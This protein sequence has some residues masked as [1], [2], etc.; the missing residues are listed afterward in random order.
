MHRQLRNALLMFLFLAFFSACNQL[1]DHAR[2]IPKDAV[3][4]VGINLKSLGKK[5]AW[6]VI[7]G[8]KLF[9]EMQARIAEKN[10]KDA[11]SGIEKSGIDFSNTLYVYVKT[12]TR[13]K[14]GNRITGLVPLSDAGQWEAYVKQMFPQAEIKQH[15]D[16]KEVSLGRDMYVGWNNKLMI[17]INT[18]S[19]S[20]DNENDGGNKLN[21]SSTM[22]QADVS[23]E[24]DNAFSVTKENS[25]IG[26]KHFS[27]LEM[28][29]H[30]ITFWLNY[31]QLMT[32]YMSGN[33]AQKMGVSLSNALWKEVT[34]TSGFDFKKG[35]IT[36]DTHWYFSNDMK[37]IGIEMG[38]T[39]VDKEMI[40]RLPTQNMDMLMDLHLS[41]KGV[42]AMMEK[43]GLL[44]LA[45]LG[46]GTQGMNVDDIL[47]GFTGDMAMVMND[48][49][50][51]TE[52]VTDSFMG[53][54]V[55]HQNQKP[56]VNACYVM[57]INKKEK[58]QKLLQLAKDNGLQSF[59]DGYVVPLDDKDSV[60]IMMDARYLVASN[61][62]ANA[63]GFLKGDFVSQ[64]MPETISSHVLGYPGA[65]YLDM[66]QLLKNIDAGISNSAHDS[67]MISESK[68]L[69]NN[70]TLY[71]GTYKDNAFEYHLDIN[72][73]NTDENSIIEL[74]DYGMKMSDA[75]K[76]K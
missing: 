57:K 15:G 76:L 38:T 68:K 50:L 4:S 2:Y 21:I 19:V 60:Y 7:T 52:K 6:N 36:G 14:G 31:D 54:V 73:M 16:R 22:G 46:L 1:P 18:M 27:D 62:F 49:S 45:N 26:N 3:A 55:V 69:L 56:S 70:I 61:K 23:A 33:M 37:D 53:Q 44:G 5:I 8:S 42:K 17:I 67:V 13:F 59:G 28:A 40:D 47:D 58:L 51:H 25:V 63:T 32:Q 9:K 12:E 24:M 10:A 35:L 66:Q 11:V 29:G 30:D 74:M 20:A 48:F 34:L 39:N 43:T 71:G 65:F 41:P 75:D 64:K 72:F